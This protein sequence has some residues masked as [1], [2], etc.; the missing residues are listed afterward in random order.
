MKINTR[1]QYYKSKR[2]RRKEKKTRSGLKLRKI[3]KKKKK[4]NMIKK[5]TNFGIIEKIKTKKKGFVA[6]D[7]NDDRQQPAIKSYEK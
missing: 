5:K 4:I 6:S 1:T 3:T 2:K 7:N